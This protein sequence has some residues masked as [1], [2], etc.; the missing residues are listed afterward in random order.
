MLKLYIMQQE[1]TNKKTRV[2]YAITKGVWGGAQEYVFSLATGLP[3]D[4]YEVSVIC[5]EG[6]AL[7][8]KLKEQGIKTIQINSLKRDIFLFNEFK[9][10]FE[11]IKIIRDEKPDILHLNSTKIGGLGG[12]AGRIC[13]VKKIIF[14]AHGWAFNENRSPFSKK[15][16]F[17]LQWL[18]VALSNITIAV[19]KKTKN[20]IEVIPG[21]KRK[22]FVIY[23]GVE[24]IY[25]DSKEIAQTKI[26]EISKAEKT[27]ITIGTISELHKNKGLDFLITACQ[28][29]PTNVS[30][31]IIG[32]GEEKE[33][34]KNL[35]REKDLEEKVYLV[36]KINNAK[37]LLRAFDIF[38][39][40]S[41]TEAL[42]YT[43][44]EAGLA[45]CAVIASRVGGIPEVIDNAKS[46]ILI[47]SGDTEELTRAIKYLIEREEKRKQFGET[48]QKNIE[49]NFSKQKMIDQ[50]IRFYIK[51]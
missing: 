44:L 25:F 31:Y 14:T 40:T 20:D 13:G 37:K 33:N 22:V 28:N 15:I 16:I 8:E 46:G 50:T 11:L 29:L 1:F 17:T 43:I 49:E 30:V 2:L 24:K 48:L 47:K 36:G 12:L 51:K 18:T 21:I 26:S 41:R 45:G 3:K 9:S 32:D 7:S 38:T 19:S 42:P 4:Q 34:L 6:N 23:N 35:I 39:L 5:G 10:F 27:R